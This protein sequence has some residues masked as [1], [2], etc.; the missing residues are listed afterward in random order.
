M[1]NRGLMSH[2]SFGFPILSAEF[3][4][5][6]MI[7][8]NYTFSSLQ[9]FFLNSHTFSPKEYFPQQSKT[10]EPKLDNSNIVLFYRQIK[11]NDDIV[12]GR[13][14]YFILEKEMEAMLSLFWNKSNVVRISEVSV[15]HE[16]YRLHANVST[17]TEVII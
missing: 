4:L 8:S 17:N 7:Y 5:P 6:R 11:K 2:H 1:M 10:V 16:G 13:P 9:L 12:T 15:K 14:Y 3:V